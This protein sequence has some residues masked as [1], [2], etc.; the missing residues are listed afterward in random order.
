MTLRRITSLRHVLIRFLAL[1][2]LAVLLGSFLGLDPPSC[3]DGS[4]HSSVSSLKTEL[5]PIQAQSGA[6]SSARA[7]RTGYNRSCGETGTTRSLPA[8]SKLQYTEKTKMEPIH[9][10]VT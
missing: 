1:R 4:S 6:S 8:S 5:S 9:L 2:Y 3:L 7:T 10:T